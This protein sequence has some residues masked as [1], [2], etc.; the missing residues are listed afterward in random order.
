LW[1]PFV[2]FFQPLWLARDGAIFRAQLRLK[3]GYFPDEDA[4]FVIKIWILSTLARR[5]CGEIFALMHFAKPLESAAASCMETWGAQAVQ[6]AR[7]IFKRLY[8]N[9]L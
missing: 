8:V 4:A 9:C 2:T 7:S 6:N 5:P 1:L 3:F